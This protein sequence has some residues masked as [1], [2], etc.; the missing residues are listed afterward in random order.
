[1]SRHVSLYCFS[2]NR[3]IIFNTNQI[4]TCWKMCFIFF[5]KLGIEQ[6]VKTCVFKLNVHNEKYIKDILKNKKG[7]LFCIGGSSSSSFFFFFY[8]SPLRKGTY[9]P[10][11]STL[12]PLRDE[13]SWCY[14][15]LLLLR[16]HRSE[17]NAATT[18]ERQVKSKL[19]VHLGFSR[20]KL[21]PG[22]NA[23]LIMA[24]KYHKIH[25]KSNI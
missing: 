12:E 15:T 11:C 10:Y 6:S 5:T 14:S 18:E 2:D 16:R 3:I 23:H 7:V 24:F 1:M 9:P 19:N 25:L 13:E 20:A 22:N 4:I 17:T 21:A 8:S